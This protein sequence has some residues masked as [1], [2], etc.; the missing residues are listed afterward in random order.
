MAKILVVDDERSLTS[1]LEIVLTRSGYEVA[2]ANTEDAGLKSFKT[3]Q[4]DLVLLDLNLGGRGGLVLLEEFKEIAPLVPVIVITAYS[5]WD[6]AVEAMRRGAYDFIKKP[7][8]D[9][10]MIREV[11]ARAIA[12]RSMLEGVELRESASEILGN[13]EAMRHVLDI[14]KRVAPTDSTVLVTGESGTGKELLSRALHYCSHRAGGPFLSVNCAALPEALLESELF[15]HVRGAF[16][17]AHI[18]K[19][20]LIEVCEQGTFFMDEV[21]ELP[22]STQVKLLRVLEDRR[23]LPVGGT[24]TRK[25]DVRFI[26]ATNRNLEDEVQAGRFRTDLYYRINVL[27][28]TLPPLRDR[29]RDVPLLAAHFLAK[30]SRRLKRDVT[31]ISPEFQHRLEE[32]HWPGNVRELENVIQRG[33]M[34]CRGD[35]LEGDPILGRSLSAGVGVGGPRTDNA[36]VPVKLPVD[37]EALLEGLERSHL[38]AALDETR[39][40]LTNAAKLLGISFRAIRYKLKK[41]DIRPDR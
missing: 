15:G 19:K 27:P 17:G 29:K 14:V 28:I 21:G 4:P 31:S 23:I 41:Y 40:H 6:N 37:L 7:F 13:S 2:T 32:H 38:E 5:T 30:Y 34:L 18:D 11:V 24:Q 33:V 20:G 26:C 25:V 10:D 1:L 9:N 3:S 35:T 39:G 12:Q 22:L 36:T 8:D 16:S